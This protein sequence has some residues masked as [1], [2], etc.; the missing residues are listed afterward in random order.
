MKNKEI[1]RINKKMK[2]FRILFGVEVEIDSNGNIDYNNKILSGF[3]FVIA[4]IHS[5]FKQT[6]DRCDVM[7]FGID[8][9]RKRMALKK[10]IISTQSINVLTKYI[11]RKL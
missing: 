7:K 3:D 2:N 4:A 8:V 1:D 5:A 11:S 10:D 9:I 6:F